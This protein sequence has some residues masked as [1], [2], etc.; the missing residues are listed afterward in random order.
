[1]D[2]DKSPNILLVGAGGIGCEIIKSLAIDGVYRITVVDFDTIS[3][4]NLSRQFFYSE[5]DIGKEK[6]I[7]LAE[8]AMKRYPNLQITGISGNVLDSSFDPDFI[9]QFDFVFCGV[10]NID[11]R[12]RISQL[13]VITQTPFIDCASSGKHAQSVPTIPFKSACYV[14]SPVAAPSGPKVT[15]TIRS[16]PQ[17][18][19]HCSAWSFHLFNAVF[20]GQGS[21]DV[22]SVDNLEPQALYDNVFVKRIEELRSKTEIWKHRVPPDPYPAK[23]T[24]NHEPITRPCDKWTLEESCG[25][26]ADVVSRLSPPLVFDKDDDDHLAFATAATNLQSHCF[27]INKAVS[28]FENK[29]LVAVVVPALATTNSI[30]SGIAVQQMK[31]MF[32]ENKL[33]VK[34]VWMS[35]SLN[36]PKLT[37]V[38]L[39]PP[40]KTCSICGYEVWHVQCDYTKTMISEV[41]KSTGINSPSILLGNNIIYDC[42]DTDDKKISEL[43]GIGNSVILVANDIDDPEVRKHILLRN[44]NVDFNAE[45]VHDQLYVKPESD[46]ECDYSDI[47]IIG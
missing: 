31:Q 2:F 20:S 21:N 27:H 37:P 9:D 12:M 40:S 24:P 30:I 41:A 7:R 11:A 3:L 44:R 38:K 35:N 6:S 47:E 29:G 34:S 13:C 32:T 33:N 23:V 16:T 26:F 18:I 42:E 46:N 10:D 8:N 45:K 36:G 17:T 19:E 4:S 43:E 14:C 5:D 39:E 22:I 25:V 15:C 1:M 28:M